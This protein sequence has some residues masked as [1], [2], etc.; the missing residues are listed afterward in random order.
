MNVNALAAGVVVIAVIKVA[1]AIF[2]GR[3]GKRIRRA[4]SAVHHV[5]DLQELCLLLVE[6]QLLLLNLLLEHLVLGQDG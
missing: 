1:L 3:G 5:A 4:D 2:V 6:S